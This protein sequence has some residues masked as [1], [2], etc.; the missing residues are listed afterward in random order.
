MSL[1]PY[2]YVHIFIYIKVN[3]LLVVIYLQTWRKAHII[4]ISDVEYIYIYVVVNNRSKEPEELFYFTSSFDDTMRQEERYEWPL[5]DQPNN[6]HTHTHSYIPYCV[7]RCMVCVCVCGHWQSTHKLAIP[8]FALGKLNASACSLSDF[9]FRSR[10]Y[11][12]HKESEVGG[13][14]NVSSLVLYV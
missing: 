1:L 2:I 7:Y 11:C 3:V 10:S 13:R 14:V 9:F 8:V 4:L 12:V 6:T 5:W